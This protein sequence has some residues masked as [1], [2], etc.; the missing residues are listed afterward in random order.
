MPSLSPKELAALDLIIEA[1]KD[2]TLPMGFI[3]DVVNAV[4]NA[5]DV[6]TKPCP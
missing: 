4:G 2:G 5:A 6:V 1:R 3:G